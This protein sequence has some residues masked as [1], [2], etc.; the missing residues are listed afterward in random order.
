VQPHFVQGIHTQR[1]FRLLRRLRRQPFMVSGAAAFDDSRTLAFF[2]THTQE[3]A[4]VAFRRGSSCVPD[5][6]RLLNHLLRDWRVEQSTSMD[7]RLFDIIWM[8]HR[9]VGSRS[10]VHIVSAYRAPVTI[11]AR[12]KRLQAVSEQSQHSSAGPWTSAFPRR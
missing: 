6:M 4:T 3:S 9:A 11:Q 2:H 10:P 5:G 7:P 12:R 8:V 1:A